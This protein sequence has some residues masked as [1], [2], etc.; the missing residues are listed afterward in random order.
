MLEVMPD[1]EIIFISELYNDLGNH[2]H[3]LRLITTIDGDK[4]LILA[5]LAEGHITDELHEE[6]LRRQ[7]LR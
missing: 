5:V 7:K 4:E 6:H 1:K 2:H 3:L